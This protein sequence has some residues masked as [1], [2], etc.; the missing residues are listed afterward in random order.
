MIKEKRLK[1]TSFQYKQ[2]FRVRSTR[3]LARFGSILDVKKAKSDMS[4][5]IIYKNAWAEIAVW[6]IDIVKLV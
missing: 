3:I 4:R 2:K 6:H 5:E 1:Y